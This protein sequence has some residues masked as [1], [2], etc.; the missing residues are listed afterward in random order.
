ML[1][2]LVA[3]G[4]LSENTQLIIYVIFGLYGMIVA[5]VLH[6]RLWDSIQD[7]Y[8]AITPGKAVGFLFI[9]VFNFYWMYRSFYGFSVECNLY[10]DRHNIDATKLPEKQFQVQYVLY[11]IAS[12]SLKVFSGALGLLA[13]FLVLVV[14]V[15]YFILLNYCIDGVNAIVQQKVE[16]F[17]NNG[18]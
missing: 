18:R 15:F 13:L 1:I 14:L 5:L 16:L 3:G 8:T 4:S 11:L 9:P 10:I 17:E 6:Y 2:T 12:F 7:Q